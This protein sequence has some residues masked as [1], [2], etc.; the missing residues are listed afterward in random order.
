MA[1]ITKPHRQKSRISQ[2]IAKKPSA[3]QKPGCKICSP[4]SRK[5]P[6]LAT[7]RTLFQTPTEGDLGFF[8]VRS[9]KIQKLFQRRYRELALSSLPNR[10][11]RDARQ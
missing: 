7:S 3:K 2:W 9:F 6:V 8:L 11:Q 5:N 1:L 4:K 10:T